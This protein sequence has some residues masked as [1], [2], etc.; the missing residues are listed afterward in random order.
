MKNKLLEEYVNLTASTPEH[1]VY[2]L[3]H[4]LINSFISGNIS[5]ANDCLDRLRELVGYKGAE[6]R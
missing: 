2:I 6:K 5:L 1:E 4:F 3:T